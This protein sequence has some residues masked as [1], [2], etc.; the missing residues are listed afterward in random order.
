MV[1]D[2]P[3]YGP[4]FSEL[5]KQF[6]HALLRLIGLSQHGGCRLAEDLGLCELR[7]FGREI[8]VFDTAAC[9]GQVGDG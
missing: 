2:Q 8:G 4:V 5:L 1:G 7:R 9:L 3:Q 6:Q